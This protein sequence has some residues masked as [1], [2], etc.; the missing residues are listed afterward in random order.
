MESDIKAENCN[1]NQHTLQASE[2]KSER[3][4]IIKIDRN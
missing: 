4:L 3:K 2:I 1:V